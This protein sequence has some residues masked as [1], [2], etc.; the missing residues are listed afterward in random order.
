M[1]RRYVSVMKNHIKAAEGIIG[2]GATSDEAY[3]DWYLNKC[4]LDLKNDTRKLYTKRRE[5]LKPWLPLDN[6]LHISNVG[7]L[8]Y[9]DNVITELATG[10]K[11]AVTQRGGSIYY[12]LAQLLGS[13]VT[14][15]DITVVL[16]T[17]LEKFFYNI[18]PSFQ[19]I[20]NYPQIQ[21]LNQSN[22]FD[23]KVK[24]YT[25]NGVLMGVSGDTVGI[26]YI[27]DDFYVA[28]PYSQIYPIAAM[29]SRI[30]YK[31]GVVVTEEGVF[32]DGYANNGLG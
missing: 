27:S 23:V 14:Y 3:E 25:D 26:K 4:S 12:Y 5:E 16:R 15:S 31:L 10:K 20:L 21:L 17:T 24:Y 1:R 7:C 13:K 18:S 28:V 6:M 8:Y 32:R 29:M 22:G 11:V 30:G 9:Q 2:F 19:S